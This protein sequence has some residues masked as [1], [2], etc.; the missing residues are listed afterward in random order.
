[1]GASSAASLVIGLELM[2]FLVIAGAAAVLRWVWDAGDT[3]RLRSYGV[4]LAGGCAAGYLGFASYDNAVPRCEVL[5]P[6]WLSVMVAAGTLAFVLAELKSAD[7]RV[8]LALA[9][10]GG[11]ALA[12]F[13]ALAWP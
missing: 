12:G 8:R 10:A 7:W 9:A 3:A 4:M 6:V 1:M 5:S 13:F 11:I 2:P